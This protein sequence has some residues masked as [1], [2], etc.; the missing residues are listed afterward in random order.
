M[1]EN[2]KGGRQRERERQERE[3]E[4]EREGLEILDFCLV[5]PLSINSV[6]D[7]LR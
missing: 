6:L 5:R 4:R 2:L 7:G 3:R 1:Q